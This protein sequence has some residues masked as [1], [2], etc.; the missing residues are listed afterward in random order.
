MLQH[1]SQ[2]TSPSRTLPYSLHQLK[3][4]QESSPAEFSSWPESDAQGDYVYSS[5]VVQSQETFLDGPY[6]AGAQFA[7]LGAAFN[8]PSYAEPMAGSLGTTG[9]LGS[10]L[11]AFDAESP[12]S[13]DGW[14]PLAFFY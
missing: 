7:N 1:P 11:S 10:E 13:N 5:P 2:P 8:Y 4:H 9:S 6:N 12:V 3:T 14:L